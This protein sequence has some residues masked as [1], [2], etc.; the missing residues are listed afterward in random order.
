M[1]KRYGWKGSR[2]KNNKGGSTDRRVFN[3]KV[4][5]GYYCNQNFEL[6]L[7]TSNEITKEGLLVLGRLK[8]QISSLPEFWFRWDAKKE[9]LDIDI[10]GD[11][12]NKENWINEE[13]GYKGHHTVKFTNGK[14][15]FKVLIIIPQ[16]KV[17]EGILSFNLEID[18]EICEKMLYRDELND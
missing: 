6:E 1:N 5:E 10:Y 11:T 12:V 8:S 18:L 4:L 17:F 14:R 2:F 15:W 13:Q 9:E 7:Y 16:Y 3:I